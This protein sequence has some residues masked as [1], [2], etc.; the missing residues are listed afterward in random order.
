MHTTMVD[1]LSQKLKLSSEQRAILEGLDKGEGAGPNAGIHQTI[2]TDASATGAV[3][4][5]QDITT[6][7]PI[8]FNA[9]WQIT[10]PTTGLWEVWVFLNGKQIYHQTGIKPNTVYT[11]GG[12]TGWGTTHLEVKGQ[13]SEARATHVVIE[14]DV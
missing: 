13:W 12:T 2:Q 1:V 11:T 10:M 6:V 3:D 4:Y 7:F 5:K 8:G 9:K 14:V